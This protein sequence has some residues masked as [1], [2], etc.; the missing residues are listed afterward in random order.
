[1]NI[2]QFLNRLL[3]LSLF[4]FTGVSLTQEDPSFC[5]EK[6]CVAPDHAR[7]SRTFFRP[8]SVLEDA[9]LYLAL[10]GYNFHRKYFEPNSPE[11][12]A[13]KIHFARSLF[14]EQS[15]N[16]GNKNI[17]R[18]FFPKK[19]SQVSIA[20]N[21]TGDVGSLWLSVIAP[22]N[23]VY[24]STLSLCP[25]RNIVGSYLDF[26]KDV[27]C[28]DGL[29]VETKFALYQVTHRLRPIERLANTNILGTLPGATTALEYLSDGD[30]KYGKITPCH[31]ELG[32]FDDIEL[33]VGYDCFRSVER[34]YYAGFYGSVIVP[35]STLPNAEHL[36]EPLLGRGHWGLGA[37][38]NGGYKVWECNNHNIT[39]LADASFNYLL[40]RTELRSLDLKSNGEW[41]RYMRVATQNQP[42][43]SYPAI[44]FTTLPLEVTPRGVLNLWAAAHYQHCNWHVEAGWNL[45]WKQ[46]EKI[47]LKN[48][49]SAATAFNSLNIGIFD[50]ANTCNPTSA[51]TANIS[52]GKTLVGTGTNNVVSDASFRALTID[53]LD[54]ASASHPRTLTNK[55]YGAVSYDI[56]ILN[57]LLNLGLGGSMEFSKCYNAL[58]QWS[59]IGTVE[60]VF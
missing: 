57:R 32:G 50:M 16:K 5:A 59:V 33:K 24:Q 9:G 45:W 40:K 39:L 48:D 26:R 6:N 30:L 11:R 41:S 20:E 29:W 13:H 36:F 44:N 7:T 1:M 56:A 42:A 2:K 15:K 8:R 37:G 19:K 28:I 21:G 10:N 27:N 52:Q 38:L 14:Y 46:A 25:E 31:M 34:G 58:E 55:V 23:E 4:L 17:A 60:L 54:L 53:D 49:C 12:Q 22:D 51:S 18:Y 35:I 3:M 47:C 43:V